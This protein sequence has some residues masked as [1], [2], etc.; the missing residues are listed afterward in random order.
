MEH[1]FDARAMASLPWSPVVMWQANLQMLSNLQQAWLHMFMSGKNGV[2]G[3]WATP[4]P[5]LAAFMPFMPKIEATVTPLKAEGS[6]A[7]VDEASRVTM[8]LTMPGLSGQHA[9]EILL[10]DAVVAR[11]SGHERGLPLDDADLPARLPKQ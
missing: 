5:F 9:S 3:Q 10:V 11:A 6:L 8:R 2:N 1:P 4:E 7:G